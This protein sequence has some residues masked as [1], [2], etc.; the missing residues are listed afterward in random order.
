MNTKTLI[1][2]LVG[3]ILVFLWQFMSWSLVNIHK[4]EQ[5]YTENQDTIIQFLSQ[6]N[7][8]DG[9]YFLPQAA[10]GADMEAQQAF[11][12]S[13]AGKPWAI[14]SYRS[15]M[16]T[17]MMMPMLRGLLVDIFAVWL[18]GW[19][20]GKIPSLTMTQTM[21]VCIVV[22]LIGYL[23]TEYTNAIWF[24]YNTLAHLADAVGCWAI[25]GAW[26]GWWRNR[27]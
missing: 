16:N 19:L 9:T 6:Q 22:A 14:V 24:E 12:Q 20:L 21:S 10:P 3:G 1:G 11:M 8:S 2:A 18:L 5:Q 25:C 17:D 15:A 4:S 23:T 7:L 13:M 27:N 26:L